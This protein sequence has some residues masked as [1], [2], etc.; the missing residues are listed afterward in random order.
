MFRGDSHS[1]QLFTAVTNDACP[2]GPGSS[3]VRTEMGAHVFYYNSSSP[4]CRRD[5]AGVCHFGDRLGE[6]E[7]VR[8]LRDLVVTNF[9]LHN[10]VRMWTF[11]EFS[12]ALDAVVADAAAG[13]EGRFAWHEINAVPHRKDA[14]T[15]SKGQP[16]TNV[17]IA[18]FNARAAQRFKALGYPII[19]AFAQTLA[20]TQSTR[21]VSHYDSQVLRQST[22]Q[23]VLGLLCPSG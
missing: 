9:G 14:W 1:R 15:L 13:W 11:R 18:L 4:E 5:L 7:R 2:S 10:M 23:F 21:D 16:Q 8:P 12:R 3:I 19:P 22:M 17:K 20:L 6:C